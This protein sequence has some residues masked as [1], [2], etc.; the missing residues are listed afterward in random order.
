MR[1]ALQRAAHQLLDT[2]LILND[3]LAL[4][5]IGEEVTQKLQANPEDQQ[6]R[7]ARG[8]RAAMVVRSRFA[9]D[10]LAGIVA[11]GIRQYVV[12]GAGLDTSAFRLPQPTER[13]RVFEVD[14]PA[15]QDW[16]RERL[17]AAGIAL[18]SELTFVPV[19]FETQN[20]AEELQSAGFDPGAPA[21]FSWLG[22]TPYLT[23][24]A[25]F[26]MLRYVAARPRGTTI[27]F[28]YVLAPAALSLIEKTVLEAMAQRVAQAGE[29]WR[30][31]FLPDELETELR[32]LGF[33]KILDAGALLLNKRYCHERADGLKVGNVVHLMRAEV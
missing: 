11:R 26:E 13:L 25:L 30:S 8:L 27:V 31:S 10:E 22:V 17:A 29:P 23:G 15:M 21:F 12:L 33:T 7:L 3:P 4:R 6:N 19:D 1:V 16:K 24:D 20:L 32:T 14:Y 28:D 9:E 2:P 5:I 18:P